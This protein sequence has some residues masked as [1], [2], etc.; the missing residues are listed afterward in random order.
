MVV[1]LGLGGC[2]GGGGGGTTSGTSASGTTLSSA[3]IPATNPSTSSTPTPSPTAS[4]TYV[5][6]AV[7]AQCHTGFPYANGYVA[8]D[9]TDSNTADPTYLDAL[10]NGSIYINYTD[11]VH[12]SP[13]LS[14]ATRTLATTDYVKCEGCH[15][16]GSQ[17]YG[18]GP[19]PYYAPG[20]AQCEA[21]HNNININ[22]AQFNQTLHANT[23]STPDEFFF[24]GSVGT[25]QA[26]IRGALEWADAAGTVPVT[27]NQH[28]QECSMC[29]DP[30][31][32]HS[33]AA[34]TNIAAGN[35]PN[36]P[37]V[38]C[39]G[40]HDPHRPSGSP[41][42][43]NYVD[44][45]GTGTLAA[46][47]PEQNLNFHPV[48]VNNTPPVMVVGGVV[49]NPAT[50]GQTGYQ[51]GA[52]NL[53]G[54][55]WIRPRIA[56]DYNVGGV[57]ANTY[58]GYTA[59]LPTGGTAGNPT[60]TAGDVLRLTTERECAA[61]HTQGQYLYGK[62]TGA[63]GS[64]TLL[65]TTHQNDVYTQWLWS[66]H[67]DYKD[68]IY[69]Y[70]AYFRFSLQNAG[71][72]RPGYPYNM[73]G[74]TGQMGYSGEVDPQWTGTGAP[75]F[76]GGISASNTLVTADASA[77]WPTGLPLPTTA[78][79]VNIGPSAAFDGRPVDPTGL[80]PIPTWPDGK[81]R[82]GSD[83]S[84]CNRCHHGIG[85][86]DYQKGTVWGN[87]I[88]DTDQAH[89]LWGDSSA[90]CITCHSAHQNGTST[91]MNV[92][93]PV[94]LSYSK[95]LT[96]EACPPSQKANANLRGG[97]NKLLD[98]NPIPSNVG[99]N[100]V[101]LVCHQGRDSG[102]TVWNTVRRYIASNIGVTGSGITTEQQAEQW[103]YTNPNTPILPL[104]LG[105]GYA[106]LW[107]TIDAHDLPVG[108]Q[109]YGEN[110]SEFLT[111]ASGNP[112]TYSSGIPDH[113]N[114]RPNAGISG[115][116]VGCHMDTGYTDPNGSLTYTPPTLTGGHTFEMTSAATNVEN[117]QRCNLCHA[118]V[119]DFHSILASDNWAGNNLGG[120]P[121]DT[122]YNNVGTMTDIIATAAAYAT[123]NPTNTLGSG[124]WGPAPGHS[125]Y[126]G[127]DPTVASNWF[128]N[129]PY[130]GQNFGGTGLLGRLNEALWDNNIYASTSG[131]FSYV[132]YNS[133]YATSS[134][135]DPTAIVVNLTAGSNVATVTTGTGFLPRLS[136]LEAIADNANTN[137]PSG[138]LIVSINTTTNTITMS[139]SA[140]ATVTGLGVK[141][142]G[143]AFTR[144][145]PNLVAI[146]FDLNLVLSSGDAAYVHDAFYIGQLMFDC[147]EHLQAYPGSTAQGYQSTGSGVDP[148]SGAP[149]PLIRPV[150]PTGFPTH[151][152]TNYA[153]QTL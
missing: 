10:A 72:F 115:G 64:T 40:C 67:A 150:V 14:G 116:C 106:N 19:I 151:S 114:G 59:E 121:Q 79:N 61:C 91:T 7:C 56:F 15:G 142:G 57:T 76:I 43:R 108:A 119:T 58:A 99:N 44:F 124:A 21:C 117:T 55:T 30:D 136:E 66:P 47:A 134:A 113:M 130:H 125:V 36:P 93:Q 60:F 153:S 105:S 69:G 63:A 12:Y 41:T 71:R 95:E 22:L 25:Q 147:I 152:A 86:I 46:V 26:N 75:T 145:T 18:T 104:Q 135:T 109:L 27:A 17:H 82:L 6:T 122:V 92:R 87:A 13:P 111:D 139:K 127:G 2:G 131:K 20:V 28:I 128:A 90:T 102:W 89:I 140:I 29:H 112:L 103:Y 39:S 3:T 50:A 11:S 37:Q 70:G 78:A 32:A 52:N 23:A 33:V 129:Y 77:N 8:G 1:L 74:W 107:S 51:F 65:A 81:S 38:S 42:Q 126:S 146:Y 4:P 88:G 35:L 149:L 24:Q 133:T 143:N 84:Y 83:N 49:Q 148:T 144:W 94:F 54:G 9:T 118:G 5:G 141:V 101:C 96:P 138:T 45:Q 110:A 62:S 80:S 98:L 73:G 137:I 85:S 68:Q 123:A 53:P 16:P 34:A 31:T 100:I 97:V 48:K 120:N 132:P